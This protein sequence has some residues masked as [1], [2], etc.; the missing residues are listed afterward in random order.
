MAEVTSTAGL[1]PFRTLFT[2]GTLGGLTD[3]ELLDRFISRRDEDAFAAL[4]H[5]H[6]PLVLRVCVAVLRDPHDAEDASQATFLI[7]ARKAASIRRRSSIGSWLFGVARRVAVRAR[8]DLAHRRA[9]E[10]RGAEMA[11]RRVENRVSS[12]NWAEVWDELERLPEK[13][14]APIIL[15]DLE[16]LSHEQ[17]A[18]Q[19]HQSAR[20]IRRRL[21]GGRGILR[22]RLAHRGLIH[23]ARSLSAGFAPA[24]IR[25]AV[26][27]DRASTIIRAAMRI[28]SGRATALA[29][30]IRV[31]SW[32][33]G[34]IATMF[35]TRL[36]AAMVLVLI[37]GLVGTG[38][39]VFARNLWEAADGQG[40]ATGIVT[41]PVAAAAD[42]R[43]VVDRIADHIKDNYTR[44]RTVNVLLQT[45]HLDRSVTKREEVTTHLPNGGTAHFVRQ[46]FSVWRERVLLRGDDLLRKSMDEDG[47][48]WAFHDGVWTQYLPKENA[49]WLRLPGQMP[50]IA[51]LD[52]RN[53]ASLEQRWLFVDRLRG[54]RVLEIG[55]TRTLDGQP[56]VA[57]LMEHTFDRG[58]KERYRCEFDAARNDLP[59]RIVVLREEDRIGIVLDITY[60]EVIPGA[61]WFLK[62]ATCKFFGQELARSPDS[63]AWRQALIVETK[64]KVHVNEPIAADVFA[65]EIPAGTRV[66][67]AVSASI[68]RRGEAAPPR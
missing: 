1:G 2:V 48:I 38:A 26:P 9:L 22:A 23:A 20:T 15:C 40:P 5:R 31:T 27:T 53:I 41:A 29:T 37:L 16:G 46:P 34:E 18:V 4:T 50:G 62:K 52:P 28:T 45:T 21:A 44:L 32:V 51:P 25:G 10:H 33:E 6:A 12:E 7:L 43:Q 30:S 65:V 47:Q 61:A 58:H 42:P 66:S 68:D 11:A 54:D 24:A 19:L 67:D 57:A 63:E 3:Q 39:G 13:Y 64:G 60:Q 14:R 17:A 35:L 8:T 36:K 56:R 59:T 55:P 49:A